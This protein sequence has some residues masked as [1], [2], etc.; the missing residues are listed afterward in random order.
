MLETKPGVGSE[1][2]VENYLYRDL[3]I[4][5]I[6]NAPVVGSD[7]LSYFAVVSNP[8]VK[9]PAGSVVGDESESIAEAKRAS[10][11]SLI[12]LIW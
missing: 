4:E 2:T 1:D 7:R 3:R 9:N 10:I 5:I 12:D 8:N 6:E 11:G